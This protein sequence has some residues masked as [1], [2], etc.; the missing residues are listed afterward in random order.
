MRHVHIVGDGVAALCC[1]HLLT[2]AGLRVS[3]DRADRRRV[4]A[5]L[6][7]DQAL[8]LI[9]DVFAQPNL[10][11]DLP[12]ID[13]RIVRWGGETRAMPHSAVAVPEGW[14]VERLGEGLTSVPS[15]D[16]DLTIDTTGLATQHRFGSRHGRAVAVRLRDPAEAGACRIEA[17]AAGWLFL[18]PGA[19]GKAWLLGVG[20]PIAELLAESR[21]I[22]ALV[23]PDG[24]V[25]PAFD[26]CPRLAEA[27]VGPG[28]LLC[29]SAAIGF[30]PIC[31][32]GA[33]QAVRAAILAAAVVVGIADGG[34]A[35]ALLGHYEAMLIAT[36][37][38]HLAMSLEYYAT[39][40]TGAWWR[41]EAEALRRGH[42]QCTPIGGRTAG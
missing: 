6:L 24:G 7:G 12:R 17:V 35:D 8:A 5:I 25:S 38:R 28:R 23:E 40:G 15:G 33:A 1:A 21:M 36:M 34:K 30:D 19:E 27:I 18:V 41:G 9:R 29:G 39:G 2:A 42:A 10:F 26:T 32:D 4:P 22:A 20:A 13:R 11:A 31:G 16:A 3:L 37:R 14:L